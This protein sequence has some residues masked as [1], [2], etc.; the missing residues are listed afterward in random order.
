MPAPITRFD[1]LA[2]TQTRAYAEGEIARLRELNDNC[3][4]TEAQ[5]AVIRGEIKALKALLKLE[6]PQPQVPTRDIYTNDN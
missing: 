4:L 3:G 1:Q 6:H 5:T 2:W